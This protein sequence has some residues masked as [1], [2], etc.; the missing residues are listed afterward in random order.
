MVQAIIRQIIDLVVKAQELDGSIGIPNLLQP[1]L[2]KE[3]MIADVL[4]HKIIS[5]KRHA[6]AC[7]PKDTSIHY[8][9]LSCKEGGSGQ[10]DRMFKE[11]QNKR[12][13]S[14]ARITR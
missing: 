14:L 1:G 12:A 3:L 11:P 4:G 9:Y 8:E 5:S 6:D 13:E 7:D 10:F 2:V